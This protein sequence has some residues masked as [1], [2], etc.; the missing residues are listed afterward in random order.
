[1]PSSSP[2]SPVLAALVTRRY[3]ISEEVWGDFWDRLRARELHPGEALAVVASLT[4]HLPDG[5]SVAALLRSLRARNEQ[6]AAPARTTVNIV[7]TGGGPS[8][9]NL[10]TASAFV[11][12]ALGARVIKTGSRA[13]ASRTG[14][15]DLLD[16][17]GMPQTTS[18]AQTEEMLDTYGMACA[19][20]FVYPKELRILARQILPFDMKTMGR[21]FN[22][23]G[24]FLAAVPV[25]T[26]ITGVSDHAVL[27]T[28]RELAAADETRRFWLCSNELGCDELLSITPSQVYDS[29]DG[30]EFILDPAAIGLSERP[31]DDLLPVD[32]L[33]STVSHFLALIGGDGPPG[34]IESIQLNAGALAINGGVA[35]DWP[36]ALEM[37]AEAMRSGAPAALIERMRNHGKE[38]SVGSAAGGV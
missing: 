3:P 30:R 21:F 28:F 26:Q 29:E 19:G 23:I 32:D 6:P 38:S 5:A 11:A 14:S 2:P 17:L 7:G 37:A 12:A 34:A 20:A 33:D 1:M 35:D 9:F 16:R 18:Y 15:V 24:P 10:S 22:V 25:S 8:T 31:F 13:Y 36:Q 27:P 4:T